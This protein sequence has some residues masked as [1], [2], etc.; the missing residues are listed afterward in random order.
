MRGLVW[1][2]WG[3]RELGGG[4]FAEMGGMRS[5]EW[6]V[7]SAVFGGNDECENSALLWRELAVERGMSLDLGELRPGACGRRM[8][9][10]DPAFS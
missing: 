7:A 3:A 6:G 5:G 8:R 4:S 2:G 1:Q 10:F 9:C